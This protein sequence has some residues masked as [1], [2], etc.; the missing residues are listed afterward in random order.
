MR[1]FTARL[2]FSATT[3]HPLAALGSS[4][5]HAG[6]G[7]NRLSFSR[8][9]FSIRAMTC[10]SQISSSPDLIRWSMLS[11]SKQSAGGSAAS[12]TSA[13][14]AWHRRNEV[15]P[16]CER[17]CPAMTNGKNGKNER[18]RIGNRTPTDAMQL[19][20]GRNRAWPRPR[21]GRRTS[22]GV[23]PRFSPRGR[24]VVLGSA[25]G[26]A[27]WDVACP[28]SGRYPPPPVPKS[29][30]APRAVVVVLGLMPKALVKA[31]CIDAAKAESTDAVNPLRI[32][33]ASRSARRLRYLQRG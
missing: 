6:R 19:F 30:N 20:A 22:I 3:P 29:S 2:R 8:S 16:F 4:S 11:R 10:H 5:R 27:S 32:G 12:V 31:I 15:T 26:H 13:W 21:Y 23:P 18:E 24:V 9:V 33:R 1:G 7:E 25:S 28:S 17:L 14:I